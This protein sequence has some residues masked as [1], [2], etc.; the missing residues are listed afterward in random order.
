[1][2]VWFYMRHYLNLR[3]LYSILTEFATIGPYEL[4]WET[5]QYKCW[6]AQIITFGLLSALQA[7]NMF[8][9]F[10]V[11]RIAYR[12]VVLKVA[13]DERSEYETDEEEEME[14]QKLIQE[15]KEEEMNGKANGLVNGVNGKA[16]LDVPANGPA[17]GMRLRS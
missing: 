8:W 17:Q 13:E 5:Q 7:V 6:L 15:D 11:V 16:M 4:N 9:G 1:M 12:M 3:I 14:R 10:L 2:C